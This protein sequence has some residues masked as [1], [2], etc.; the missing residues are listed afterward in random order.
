MRVATCVTVV[1]Y[2]DTARQ[3]LRTQM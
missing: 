3:K 2:S 1:A